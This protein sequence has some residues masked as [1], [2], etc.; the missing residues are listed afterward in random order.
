MTQ[1]WLAGKFVD[2]CL[3][4]LQAVS[5]VGERRLNRWSTVAE[6]VKGRNQTQCRERWCNVLD[7]TLKT[8]GALPT[9]S[10]H[11]PLARSE[12]DICLPDPFIP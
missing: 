7:P 5:I 8:G 1:P 11:P 4:R 6:M 9:C 3:W 12:A 2:A 10:H